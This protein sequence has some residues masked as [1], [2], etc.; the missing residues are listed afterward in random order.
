MR[1]LSTRR[2]RAATA[3]VAR[4]T[5]RARPGRSAAGPRSLQQGE[6]APRPTGVPAAGLHLSIAPATRHPLPRVQHLG[7]AARRDRRSAYAAARVATGASA[8]RRRRGG[9]RRTARRPRRGRRRGAQPCRSGWSGPPRG[10]PPGPGRRASHHAVAAR[11][12][13]H[14]AHARAGPGPRPGAQKS[15]QQSPSRQPCENNPG[16]R[17]PPER[18]HG[19]GVGADQRVDLE[20]VE[21]GRAHGHDSGHQVGAAGGQHLANTPPRLW[22]T[23]AARRPWRSTRVSRRRRGARCCAP[24]QPTLAL[25]PARPGWWPVPLSQ[26]P[27]MRQGVVA[28]HEARDQQH[29]LAA[30]RR[31]R[32]GRGTRRRG[33]ARPVP[34][35]S[36]T[37]ARAADV[38]M[39]RAMGPEHEPP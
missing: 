8:L 19:L 9:G 6:Q 14:E 15:A 5:S 26:R 25:I 34:G 27:I 16:T 1:W 4:V 21:V 33:P 3:Q 31:S 17:R 13:R 23:I 38:G 28:G 2:S 18:R 24:E 20:R 30:R 7:R 36:G 11:V 22:P 29:G 12:H 39:T 37:R 32:P 10:R 35:P